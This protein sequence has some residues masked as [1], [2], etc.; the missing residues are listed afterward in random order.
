[1]SVIQFPIKRPAQGV[2]DVTPLMRAFR[3]AQIKAMRDG[4]RIR[5]VSEREPRLTLPPIHPI[6]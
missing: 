2:S 6:W 4:D 1:M 3:A 5:L